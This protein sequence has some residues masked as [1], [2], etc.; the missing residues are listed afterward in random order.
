MTPRRE[1]NFPNPIN[2]AS[3]LFDRVSEIAGI[4]DA[5]RSPGP[6]TAVIMGE[7]RIG[8]TSLLNVVLAWAATEDW[9]TVLR[10]PHVTTRAEFGEEILDGI[11]AEAGTSLYRLGLRSA[12]DHQAP[13][14]V[15]AFVRVARDLSAATGRTFLVCLDELD[16]MLVNCS[17]PSANQIL[18]F[19]LHLENTGLPIR[20]LF[21]MTRATPRILHADASPFITAAHITRLG[22]WNRE[23][24]RD[25]FATL[26]DGAYRLDQAAHDRLYTAGGGH[27]YLIKAITKCLIEAM[28]APGPDPTVSAESIDAAAGAALAMPEVDFTLENIVTAHFSPDELSVLRLAAS[29]SAP[30][31]AEQLRTHAVAVS[32][33]V[34]RQ[35]LRLEGDA[36]VLSLGLLGRWLAR[37]PG[38]VPGPG[39]VR[40]APGRLAGD[41]AV[42]KLVVD[43]RR[44]RVF[45]G[46]QEIQLTPQEYQFLKCVA[47]QAGIVVDRHSVTTEVW[48][49]RVAFDGGRE[50]RLDA[51]VHRLREAL[52]TDHRRYIETRRGHGYY[53]NPDHVE[54][55][56]GDSHED[57]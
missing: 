14:T 18:D 11:A 46:D 8:K 54:L 13:S 2:D 16:S 49:D 29:T 48:P 21:T 53:A 37:L 52:G 22:L 19:I 38:P 45:L 50:N 35:Y 25:F 28:G 55:I 3:D 20:F 9:L 10:L 47:G 57:H 24:V 6:R 23:E 30:I 34:R 44:G 39:S 51:L 43:G 40:L 41:V 33:L 36:Y 17:S 15:A 12:N 27:P 31:G 4:K 5:I 1:L 32:E 26:V 42:A 56:P 7:R